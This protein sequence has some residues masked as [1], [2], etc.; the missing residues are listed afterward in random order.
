ML[1]AFDSGDLAVIKKL[2]GECGVPIVF[3]LGG[4]SIIFIISTSLF[5]CFYFV[6]L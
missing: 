4:I 1:E 2:H 5:C 6:F 3:A